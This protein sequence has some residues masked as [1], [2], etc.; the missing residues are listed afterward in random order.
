MKIKA[1]SGIILELLLA[2]ILMFAFK[3]PQLQASPDMLPSDGDA[4]TENDNVTIVWKSAGGYQETI[5][6]TTDKAVN[7]SYSLRANHTSSWTRMQ[8]KGTF[9]VTQ[10]VSDYDIL[11]LYMRIDSADDVQKQI[12]IYVHTDASNHACGKTKISESAWV[13]VVIPLDSMAPTNSPDFTSIAYLLFRVY[14]PIGANDYTCVYVD[15]LYFTNYE[16]PDVDGTIDYTYLPNYF[17]WYPQFAEYTTFHGGN[18]YTTLSSMININ[19]GSQRTDTLESESLGQTIFAFSKAYAELGYPFLL[20]KSQLYARWLYQFPT[21]NSYGAPPYDHVNATDT[22]DATTSITIAAWVLAG[23]SALYEVDN[24]ATWK[25]GAD[26]VMNFIVT[27]MWNNATDSPYYYFNIA[28]G[29]PSGVHNPMGLGSALCG[30]SSYYNYVQQNATVKAKAERCFDLTTLSQYKWGVPL[31]EDTWYCYWG[32]WEASKFNVT[33]RAMIPR[34][35]NML[36][37]WAMMTNGS[38][39]TYSS[40][41]WGEMSGLTS[42][43][44][45]GNSLAIGFLAMYYKNSSDAVTKTIFEN[46]VWDWMRQTQSSLYGVYFTN[47]L[48]YSMWVPQMAFTYLGLSVMFDLTESIPYLLYS[49]RQNVTTSN[50]ASDQLTFTIEASTEQTELGVYCGSN[51]QPTT[52]TGAT[53][54]YDASSTVLTLTVTHSSSQEVV[55]DWTVTIPGDIDGD[56]DIDFDD[57]IIFAG[58]YRTDEG[59]PT[60]DPR[61]DLDGDGD[62]DFDD[63]IIFAG[64]YGKTC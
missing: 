22:F 64:N 58:P 47:Y 1:V 34:G 28:T 49:T 14:D 15:G 60:F 59:D 53:Y 21:N 19:D 54:S 29:T 9:N 27:D 4:W 3:I 13:K 2:S 55:L 6:F 25:D 16:A 40:S 57:F 23:F 51:G 48:S 38:S 42:L 20:E 45:W 37:A 63:F 12:R 56:G 35:V 18:T 24:N 11:V 46:L 61:C 5:E 32:I 44:G 17:A 62:I 43:N 39:Y 30:L 10:D 52:V 36:R 41:Y 50:Y 31:W 33:I 8:W 26:L 7:G